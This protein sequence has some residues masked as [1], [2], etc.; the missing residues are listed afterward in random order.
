LEVVQQKSAL[1]YFTMIAKSSF[2]ANEGQ[3]WQWAEENR[4]TL[5]PKGQDRGLMVS[6]FIDEHY[7]F[8]RLTTE[9][10][11]L[12]KMSHPGLPKA[13]SSLVLKDKAI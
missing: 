5:R 6:Y 1:Y 2:H 7:G 13:Y 3:T 12:A 10:H 9:E 8:L 4:L 11:E